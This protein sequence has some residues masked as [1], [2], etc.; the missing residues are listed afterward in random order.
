MP[1]RINEST[2]IR[3]N[4]TLSEISVQRGIG[5]LKSFKERSSKPVWRFGLQQTQ[6]SG[7][8]KIEGINMATKA[9][10]SREDRLQDARCTGEQEE[11][12]GRAKPSG[13]RGRVTRTGRTTRREA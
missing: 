13:G 5:L 6:L 1:G 4:S 10:H 9:A 7:S 12:T 11:E 3:E 8:G 2:K